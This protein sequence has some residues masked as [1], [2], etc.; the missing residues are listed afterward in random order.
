MAIMR[1]S[2][3]WYVKS[4]G[5]WHICKNR[6]EAIEKAWRVRAWNT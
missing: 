3:N 2:G 4:I 6:H 1:K 5:L